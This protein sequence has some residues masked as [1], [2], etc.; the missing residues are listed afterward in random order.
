MDQNQDGDWCCYD[1]SPDPVSTRKPREHFTKTLLRV[2]ERAASTPLIGAVYVFGSYARG[3]LLCGDLDLMVETTGQLPRHPLN[4]DNPMAGLRRIDPTDAAVRS[5]ARGLK[6]VEI[7]FISTPTRRDPLPEK[8]GVTPTLVWSREQPDTAANLATITPDPNAGR[9]ERN[10]FIEVKRTGSTAEEMKEVMKK[11]QAGSLL[12]TVH[13]F[14]ERVWFPKRLQRQEGN[15]IS[16]AIERL[17]PVAYDWF[18]QRGIRVYCSDSTVFTHVPYLAHIGRIDLYRMLSF[19][20]RFPE[21]EVCLIPHLKKGVRP[22][23]Y[24]FKN[25]EP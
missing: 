25:G 20:D 18:L 3:A 23:M 19:L 24:V 13:P 9:Y 2:A 11:I 12:M 8:W 16:D 6:G 1:A 7:S 22:E 17:R 10:H 5:L 14:P 15:R 4:E 21:G